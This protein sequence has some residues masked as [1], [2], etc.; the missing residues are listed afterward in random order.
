[1][2]NKNEQVEYLGQWVDRSSFRTFIYNE[3]GQKLVES[4]D[5]YLAD[6]SSGLWW[7]TKEK[8]AQ[9]ESDLA[10][11]NAENSTATAVID[12]ATAVDEVKVKREKTKNQFRQAQSL[13]L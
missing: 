6:I 7:P 8:T 4:Y 12:A 13:G 10:P 1:M 11:L 3:T 2:T 5:Q 9:K